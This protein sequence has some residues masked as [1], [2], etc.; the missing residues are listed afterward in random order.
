MLFALLVIEMD[1]IFK[2][3]SSST[4]CINKNLVFFRSK[5]PFFKNDP[6]RANFMGESI[7]R[8]FND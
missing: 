2:V 8:I 6:I 7:E 3:Y 5:K 4:G 1:V